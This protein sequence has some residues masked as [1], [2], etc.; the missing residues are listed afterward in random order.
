[1]KLLPAIDLSEGKAV[2]LI[3]GDYQKKTVFNEDPLE[4]AELFEKA[5]ADF[6]H[7]VDLDG[8]KAGEPKNGG[9]IEKLIRGSRLK[10]EI[11]GG[12]RSLETVR[13]YLDAGAWR[14]ILGTAAAEDPAVLTECLERYGE[15]IA[16][17]ADVWDGQVMTRGWLAS[18]IPGEEFFSRL[19]AMGVRNVICTD[20]S[21]D[22]MMRGA[23]LELY[24]QLHR[25]FPAL[26]LT[27]SGGISRPEELEELERCGMDG[28]IIGKALY[29]GAIDLAEAALRFREEE[30]C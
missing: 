5:G 28:A 11:G 4:Q 23:N 9:I 27:A 14:V 29:T 17:G 13:R 10:V 16:V 19:A 1:M 25:A 18:G 21:R 30:G 6:L 20:I 24:R 2:R 3:Q 7:V 8:A 26:K 15:S 22:G 12:V